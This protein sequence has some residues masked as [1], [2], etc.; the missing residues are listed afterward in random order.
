[1]FRPQ[2]NGQSKLTNHVISLYLWCLAGDRPN[3]W[4]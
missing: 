3:S 1:V 4:L 2:T